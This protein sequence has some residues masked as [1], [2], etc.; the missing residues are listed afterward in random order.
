MSHVRTSSGALAGSD[1]VTALL[2]PNGNPNGAKDSQP[3]WLGGYITVPGSLATDALVATF[4]S[5]DFLSDF[6]IPFM[7]KGYERCALCAGQLQS[8]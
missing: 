1:G 5:A 6:A 8:Q 7:P 4:D 3:H 2:T